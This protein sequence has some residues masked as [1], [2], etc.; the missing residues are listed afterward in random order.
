MV[1]TVLRIAVPVAL[2][3]V[4]T[5]VYA[6][7]CLVLQTQF[8]EKSHLPGLTLALDIDLVTGQLGGEPRVLAFLSDRQRQL[9]IRHDD[10]SFPGLL[11]G[12]HEN[13]LGRA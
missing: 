3:I 12:H 2:V 13:D 5:L 10:L 8:L 4:V 7:L 9:V 6:F 11:I 1:I